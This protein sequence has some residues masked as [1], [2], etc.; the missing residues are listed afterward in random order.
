MWRC[1]S[2]MIFN[3]SICK[4]GGSHEADGLYS[5]LSLDA[6][7]C[8]GLPCV[9]TSKPMCFP[10]YPGHPL[11]TIWERAGVVKV[12]LQYESSAQL[13]VG[14]RCQK[15]SEKPP[16]VE[17]TCAAKVPFLTSYELEYW[18]KDVRF[19]MMAEFQQ[20]SQ[21]FFRPGRLDANMKLCFEIYANSHHFISFWA[22]YSWNLLVVC[23]VSFPTLVLEYM[24]L[25]GVVRKLSI[26]SVVSRW[27]NPPWRI[28]GQHRGSV[29]DVWT[30]IFL[31]NPILR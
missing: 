12:S 20:L 26:R 30:I 22:S 21:Q 29:V 3:A 7:S 10:S 18:N 31:P 4:A 27:E 1:N 23:L 6:E 11:R 17:T 9:A 5:N 19:S 28:N 15:R 16:Q 8:A 2:T 13:L 24:Q 25:S 14:V